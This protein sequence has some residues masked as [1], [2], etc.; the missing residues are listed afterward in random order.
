MD[1]QPRSPFGAT[2]SYFQH[3]SESYKVTNTDVPWLF[4][5]GMTGMT[6]C[7]LPLIDEGQPAATYK[8]R[9]YFAGLEGDQPKQRVFDIRLQG[10]TV[11]KRVDVVKQANAPRQAMTLEFD[12]VPV[13]NN[14]AIELVPVSA[15]KIRNLP[16]ICAIE[17]VRNGSD[18]IVRK[19]AR[20]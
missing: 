2:G 3:N 6:R 12:D 7:E 18:E 16:S 1:L 20:D 8:V 19:L 14:L 13:T 4:S 5:S 9:L 17:V 10:Q 11:S 15:S